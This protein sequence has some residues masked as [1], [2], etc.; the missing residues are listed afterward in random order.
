MSKYDSPLHTAKRHIWTVT[1]RSGKRLSVM[2]STGPR[3]SSQKKDH[4]RSGKD[5][6]LSRS[7]VH[8]G[9]RTTLRD[10]SPSAA[11]NVGSVGQSQDQLAD[12]E[13]SSAESET[14]IFMEGEDGQNDRD[15]AHVSTPA[16]TPAETVTKPAEEHTRKFKVLSEKLEDHF[17]DLEMLA[18]AFRASVDGVSREFEE[19]KAELNEA[20]EQY[21]TLETDNA[22]AVAALEE[23]RQTVCDYVGKL[24]NCEAELFHVYQAVPEENQVLLGGFGQAKS[25]AP[26]FDR[27]A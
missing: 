20:M 10:S 2:R 18:I 21:G 9:G 1:H 3:R 19:L 27:Y 5:S 24:R 23:E 13:E 15:V 22:T 8:E 26:I 25:M 16:P 14:Y 7:L 11:D 12:D 6:N 4:R 17:V